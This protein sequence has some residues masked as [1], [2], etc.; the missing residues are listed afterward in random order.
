MTGVQTCALPILARVRYG[1][2]LGGRR[3][4]RPGLTREGTR[5]RGERRPRGRPRCPRPRLPLA[6]LT[7]LRGAGHSWVERW[8][9]TPAGT[10]SGV[11]EPAVRAQVCGRMRG[12]WHRPRPRRLRAAAGVRRGGQVSRGPR[13]GVTGCQRPRARGEAPSALIRQGRALAPDSL[14]PEPKPGG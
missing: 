10:G 8:P 13:S 3:D 2:G 4:L 6:A 12:S 1:A 7:S 11:E 5:Q 14:P 9:V